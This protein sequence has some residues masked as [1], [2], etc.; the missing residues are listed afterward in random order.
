MTRSEAAA[1][2]IRPGDPI[3]RDEDGY[4]HVDEQTVDRGDVLRVRC[5]PATAKVVMT[6]DEAV[7]IRW[8][9]PQDAEVDDDEADMLAIWTDRA[10]RAPMLWRFDPDPADA[11]LTVGDTVEVS[12]PPAVVHV[13]YAAALYHDGDGDGDGV[14]LGVLPYGV[15]ESTTISPGCHL[16]IY[17]YADSPITVE[18]LHRPYPFLRDHDQ[19]RDAAGQRW[20]F[21]KPLGW[22]ALETGT[23]APAL[24]APQ[25]PLTLLC[26][27]FEDA[28]SAAE[29]TAVAESTGTGSHAD[30]V[31]AW[32]AAAGT[33]LAPPEYDS[34][35]RLDDDA[36][37]AE[38][39]RARAD[40]RGLSTEE[41]AREH[42]LAE[43]WHH[44]VGKVV[45]SEADE[46]HLE[47][48]TVRLTE[49]TRVLDHL[50]QHGLT[51]YDGQDIPQ[52]R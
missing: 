29:Q 25:W 4:A 38:A 7:I 47:R 52:Y 5:T 12:I 34:L 49:V 44:D 36:R 11:E 48:V 43:M 30:E 6:T 22:V 32:C 45:I 15:Q 21:F 33:V 46:E 26:R 37:A 20:E 23:P 3:P 35:P 40:L 50:R 13:S 19:V 24:A 1:V 41:I 8:P 51:G 31:A 9:W 10:E 14:E 39:A 27:G 42:R 2:V 17:P 28:T 18:R 16:K